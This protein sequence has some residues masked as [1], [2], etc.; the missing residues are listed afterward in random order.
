M[1]RIWEINRTAVTMIKAVEKNINKNK[2]FPLALKNK[3]I[4]ENLSDQE[5][6]VATESTISFLNTLF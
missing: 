2:N 1:I 6:F 3:T 5:L 4:E